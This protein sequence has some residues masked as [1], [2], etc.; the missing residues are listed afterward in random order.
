MKILF[1][2]ALA[3]L[4]GC[5]TNKLPQ[6]VAPAPRPVVTG[7]IVSQR[8]IYA[9]LSPLMA[10]HYELQLILMDSVY[11]CLSEEDTR[12][13]I[14][15]AFRTFNN[16]Y[17]EEARDCDDLGIE[18]AVKLRTLFRRD[19]ANVPLSSTF[20]L[21]GGALVGDILELDFQAGDEP[22]YHIMV[23]VRCAGGKWLLIEP[24]SKQVC[25]FTGTIYEG[26]F[27]FILGIF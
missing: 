7:V 17:I 5:A 8:A 13:I 22:L 3:L 4:I 27:E 14:T 23:L 16:N 26:S 20:G 2:L 11:G 15:E 1:T 24:Q 9:E 10:Q 25:E 21:V 12:R 6:F 19:T 18:L